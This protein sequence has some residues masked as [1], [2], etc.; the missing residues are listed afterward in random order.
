[1]KHRSVIA[2]VIVAAALFSLPQ[3]SHDLQ[4]LK[5]AVGAR[6][7]RELLH[8]FL[9]MPA[10]E[11]VSAAPAA[12][13]AE[14]LLA[15]CPQERS[16]SEGVK[17]RRAAASGRAAEKTFEQHAMIGDPINDPLVQG[18]KTGSKD[19]ADNI[20]AAL[21]E[22]KVETEV[23]MIIPPDS[24]IDPRALSNALASRDAARVEANEFRRVEAEGLRVAYVAAAA[25]FDAKG[26][27]WQ[28]SAEEVLRNLN[29]SRPGTY[30]FRVVRD[31]AKTKVLKFKCAECPAPAPRAPRP[32]RQVASGLPLPSPVAPAETAGE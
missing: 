21:P 26:A 20:I 9:S 17:G 4:A 19:A 29:G 16:G 27:E 6:L 18:A 7:H 8:A 12:R 5:G 30:E 3:L 13:P 25:R 1:M 32:P 14:T 28:K 2:F 23:A 31:G 11:P 15:S 22:L 10:G 24:G